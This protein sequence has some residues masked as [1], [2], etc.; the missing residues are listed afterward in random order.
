MRFDFKVLKQTQFIQTES[1][2]ILLWHIVSFSVA[3][4]SVASNIVI[5]IYIW[6]LVKITS[7]TAPKQGFLVLFHR[8]TSEWPHPLT[9]QLHIPEISAESLYWKHICAKL[10]KCSCRQFLWPFLRAKFLNSSDIYQPWRSRVGKQSLAYIGILWS[11][12][13]KRTIARID[14]VNLSAWEGIHGSFFCVKRST[15]KAIP[16]TNKRVRYWG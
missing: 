7:D 1:R 10:K 13:A 9:Q 3:K 16:E 14:C 12:A 8:I 2:I 6:L 5:T 15:L 4:T 11:Y